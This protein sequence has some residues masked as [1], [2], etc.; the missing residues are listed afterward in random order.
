MKDLWKILQKAYTFIVGLFKWVIAKVL[1]SEYL[2]KNIWIALVVSI[3]SVLL[4]VSIIIFSYSKDLNTFSKTTNN[5]V[6]SEFRQEFLELD[7]FIKTIGLKEITQNRLNKVWIDDRVSSYMYIDYLKSGN[8]FFAPKI[9]RLND[10]MKHR[11][12]LYKSTLTDEHTFKITSNLISHLWPEKI[13][14]YISINKKSK[15]P[16]IFVM[17][18]DY[19]FF[20]YLTHSIMGYDE[21]P[22]IFYMYLKY[23]DHYV[24]ATSYSFDSIK[25]I[26][27]D[28]HR[29]F[30]VPFSNCRIVYIR[31]KLFLVQSEIINVKIIEIMC[32]SFLDLYNV[33]EIAIILLISIAFFVTMALNIIVNLNLIKYKFPIIPINNTQQKEEEDEKTTS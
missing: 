33:I 23:K 13:I 9:E 19:G 18:V 15:E 1:K 16:Y 25:T 17:G 4:S 26:I 7:V 5:I 31:N 30:K 27:K 12:L 2:A 28:P 20:L 6:K 24:D 21:N 32:V 8:T 22:F 29:G 10:F 11:L 3:F 14:E